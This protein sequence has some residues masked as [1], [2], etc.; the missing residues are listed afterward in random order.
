MQA[1][2]G[3]WTDNSVVPAILPP[4][5]PAFTNALPLFTRFWGPVGYY[6]ASGKAPLASTWGYFRLWQDDMLTSYI[7]LHQPSGTLLGGHTGCVWVVRAL[8]LLVFNF[9][10]VL[11]DLK[12]PVPPPSADYDL[13]CLPTNELEHL[14]GWCRIWIEKICASTEILKQTS[15]DRR[16][17]CLPSPEPSEPSEPVVA[18]GPAQ[19]AAGAAH[20]RKKRKGKGKGKGKQSRASS[21]D[22]SD[23]AAMPLADSDES[24]DP[25]PELNYDELDRN[26]DNE[27]DDDDDGLGGPSTG[28][29]GF[30]ALN[31]GSDSE[32]EDAPVT[33]KRHSQ[34]PAPS[35]TSSAS[36]TSLILSSINS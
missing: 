27:S 19:A 28:W 31:A 8:I 14:L 1:T 17:R 34:K 36:G 9:A 25:G 29:G 20:R 16:N 23:D 22:D 15:T 11:G 32:D 10:A 4:S 26:G 12:P 35:G 13:S 6:L 18:A 5:L 21:E 33:P 3:L 7:L 30:G 24:D 2:D